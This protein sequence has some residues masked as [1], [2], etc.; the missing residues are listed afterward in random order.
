M[1]V[2][3]PLALDIGFKDVSQNTASYSLWLASETLADTAFAL[4]TALARKLEL[5]SDAE[6][7]GCTLTWQ[8]ERIPPSFPTSGEAVSNMGCL[9][10]LSEDGDYFVLPIPSIKESLF[11][12]DDT[13]DRTET[14]I[15]TII[16]TVVGD[17]ISP[18]GGEIL[19]SYVTGY[20]QVRGGSRNDN[21][22][23]H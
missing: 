12:P 6:V 9:F 5:I 7:V 20:R 4:A 11:F 10:F 15:E 18:T 22:R 1:I 23:L 3:K 8:S 13:I 16:D 2:H 17:C 14:E 21:N 19:T